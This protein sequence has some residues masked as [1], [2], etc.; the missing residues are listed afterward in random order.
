MNDT[1][2]VRLEHFSQSMLIAH[3]FVSSTIRFFVQNGVHVHAR[4]DTVFFIKKI[5]SG[6]FQRLYFQF[7]NC[8]KNHG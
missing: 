7:H 5:C 1:G 4:C 6:T 8:M 2:R 3:F